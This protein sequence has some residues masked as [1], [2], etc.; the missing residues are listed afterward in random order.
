MP[1]SPDDVELRRRQRRRQRPQQTAPPHTSMTDGSSLIV[2][3]CSSQCSSSSPLSLEQL[4]SADSSSP[5]TV[6]NSEDAECEDVDAES[7]STDPKEP[8]DYHLFTA[9]RRGESSPEYSLNI[10]F[11]YSCY[12]Y[13]RINSRSEKWAS[14]HYYNHHYYEHLDHQHRSDHQ[15]RRLRPNNCDWYERCGHCPESS[16]GFLTGPQSSSQAGISNYPVNIDNAAAQP[17]AAA[18]AEQEAAAVA[19]AAAVTAAAAAA[20]LGGVLAVD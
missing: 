14:H 16:G 10:P 3:S 13:H 15:C 9:C 7:V 11:Y 20:S 5:H 12:Y 6:S 18:A 2:L 1:G 8:Y 4:A 17:I 19:A